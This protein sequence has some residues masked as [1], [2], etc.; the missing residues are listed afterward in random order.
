M[1]TFF[2][3]GQQGGRR[4]GP[5]DM[6]QKLPEPKIPYQHIRSSNLH[7]PLSCHVWPVEISKWCYKLSSS[8]VQIWSLQE[9]KLG[10]TSLTVLSP[11]LC[12]LTK[13]VT[14]NFFPVKVKHSV[15]T[16]HF[17]YAELVHQLWKP[18]NKLRIKKTSHRFQIFLDL[19]PLQWF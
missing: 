18:Y 8:L 3:G 19:Y 2:E 10:K 14:P 4:K 17:S 6:K 12:G 13:S 7:H 15:Q 16:Q 11:Q 9:R 1:I 5:F